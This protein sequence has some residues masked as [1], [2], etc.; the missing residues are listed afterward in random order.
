MDIFKLK[1]FNPD[2]ID[3]KLLAYIGDG[4]YDLIIRLYMLEKNLNSKNLHIKSVKFVNAAFQEKVILKIFD[5]LD[6]KE[7]DICKN[8][9]NKKVNSKPKRVSIITY[10]NA[11]SFE[12]LIG[13]WFLKDEKKKIDDLFDVVFEIYNQ[14]N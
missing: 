8:A 5:K 3:T 1:R 13:Y 9:R 6:E 4:I 12:A 11:T 10:R 14:Q 2:K 7:K